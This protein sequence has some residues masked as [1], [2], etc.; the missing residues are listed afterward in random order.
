MCFQYF[1]RFGKITVELNI[2]EEAASRVNLHILAK[3]LWNSNLT[4]PTVKKSE[5]DT[6]NYFYPRSISKAYC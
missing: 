2:F 3:R 6:Y 4:H 1:L 5:R